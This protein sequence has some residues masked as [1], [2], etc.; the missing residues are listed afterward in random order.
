MTLTR[1][2]FNLHKRKL[3]IQQKQINA[4]GK[5]VW[6]VVRHADFIFLKDVKFKVSEVGRQR[7]I[8]EKKKNVHAFVTGIQCND[9]MSGDLTKVFY[10]PYK[11]SSFVN[12]NG[13]P[14]H[15]ASKVLVSGNKTGY[16]ILKSE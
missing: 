8:R 15:F 6:K 3:S 2:Y 13:E 14:I 4:S 16:S 9:S 7:V 1:V 5:L 12:E 10:N 11:F